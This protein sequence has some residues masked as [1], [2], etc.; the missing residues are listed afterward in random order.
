MKFQFELPGE[1]RLKIL[2]YDYNTLGSND[3]IGNCSLL[4][5]P[6]VLL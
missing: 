4:L 6:L 2:T 3:A 5:K 1:P